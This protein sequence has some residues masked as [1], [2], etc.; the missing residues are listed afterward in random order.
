MTREFECDECGATTPT[1]AVKRCR[2]CGAIGRM[3]EIVLDRDARMEKIARAAI[4][5]VS[6]AI[7]ALR[8]VG[9]SRIPLERAERAHAE[10][11]ADFE[12]TELMP[13]AKA[14]S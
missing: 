5:E 13:A 6:A 4:E 1:P 10:L 12:N 11:S 14:V 3:S 8:A 7:N 2:S 9:Y